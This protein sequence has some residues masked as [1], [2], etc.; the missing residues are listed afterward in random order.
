MSDVAIR[1]RGEEAKSREQSRL[2]AEREATAKVE[3]AAQTAKRAKA[4]AKEAEEAEVAAAKALETERLQR[5][6][7][8]RVALKKM[9]QEELIRMAKAE[10]QRRREDEEALQRE[11][12]ERATRVEEGRRT[13]AAMELKQK[14]QEEERVD[15]A[16]RGDRL[17]ARTHIDNR[18]SW[19]TSDSGSAPAE[20]SSGQNRRRRGF[21]EETGNGMGREFT[22][23][24]AN[25]QH[26]YTFEKNSR[27][28]EEVVP[29][30]LQNDVDR[31]LAAR[32]KAKRDRDYE[33]ADRMREELN[34]MGVKVFD[35]ERTWSFLARGSKR[36]H[37]ST[38]V[39]SQV[40]VRNRIAGSGKRAKRAD[41]VLAQ[42]A[43][44]SSGADKEAKLRQLMLSKMSAAK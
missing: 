27:G 3:R 26:D 42:N 28:T 11:Q 12:E 29:I 17:S 36:Q 8:A 38:S 25:S 39:A 40:H 1:R 31:I 9:H 43:D 22:T 24:Q 4:A 13:L 10:E 6:E 5:E 18:P 7:R 20:N 30:E 33:S 35:K 21:E 23:R 19:M 41:S 15:A 16:K 32:T 2:R 44:A 37:S 14:A 34:V